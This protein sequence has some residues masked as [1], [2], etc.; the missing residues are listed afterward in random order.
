MAADTSPVNAPWESAQTSWA[1]RPMGVSRNIRPT[2]WRYT[3]GGHT[4]Q[5]EAGSDGYR[6]ASSSISRALSTREPCIFQFPTTIGRRIVRPPDFAGADDN[7]GATVV[8]WK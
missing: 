3:S 6:P 1:P 2:S 4:T 5:S 8:Q 7:G